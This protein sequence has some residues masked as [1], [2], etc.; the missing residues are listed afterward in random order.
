MMPNRPI[1][2]DPWPYLE[3]ECPICDSMNTKALGQ[4]MYR[5]LLCG[6]V[7]Q[8]ADFRDELPKRQRRIQSDEEEDE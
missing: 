4:G 1:D 2:R 7:F 5:C 8:P 6:E 3:G